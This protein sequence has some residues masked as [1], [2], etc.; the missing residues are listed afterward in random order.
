MSNTVANIAAF[1]PV[2]YRR[3]VYTALAFVGLALT[4]TAVGFASVSAALP[5]WLI[6]IQSVYAAVAAGSG[7]MAKVNTPS[8]KPIN[9]V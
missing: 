6:A 4:A 3:K 1:I 7:Y 5:A 8:E 9:A 2:A